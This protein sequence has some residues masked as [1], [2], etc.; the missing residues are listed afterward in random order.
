S[1]LSYNPTRWKT[2]RRVDLSGEA[3][4][5]VVHNDKLPFYVSTTRYKVMVLGTTFNVKSYPGAAEDYVALKSGKVRIGIFNASSKTL[6]ITPGNCFVFDNTSG[7]YDVKP[8]DSH[9]FSWEDGEIV[10]DDQ[11]IVQKK[12]ELYRLYG[13]TFRISK[14]CSTMSYRASF[15]KEGLNEMMAVFAHITPHMSYKIDDK[16]KVVSIQEIIKEQP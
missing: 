15:N 14:G 12:A 5:D 7:R 2:E 16:N 6:D 11:T 8:T 4:F 3:S 9:L 1:K 10:F 13:Y